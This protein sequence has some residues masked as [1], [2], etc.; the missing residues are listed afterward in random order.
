VNQEYR[1]AESSVTTLSLRVGGK[2]SRSCASQDRSKDHAT[3]RLVRASQKGKGIAD[4][5]FSRRVRKPEGPVSQLGCGGCLPRRPRTVDVRS[6]MAETAFHL[7][8]VSLVI[9][10]V[11]DGLVVSR[12][13]LRD[14]LARLAEL[15]NRYADRKPDLADLCLIRLSKNKPV[16][17]GHHHGRA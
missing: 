9:A 17:H 7:E 2:S 6:R 14:H 12:F 10:M 11:Q 15:A 4:T 16:S 3:S 5:G 8:N 1:G 13:A